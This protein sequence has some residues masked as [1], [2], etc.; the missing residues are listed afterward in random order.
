MDCYC[1]NLLSLHWPDDWIIIFK[2]TAVSEHR[3]VQ[4]MQMVSRGRNWT[5]RQINKSSDLSEHSRL[6]NEF[7][8]QGAH[9]FLFKK[10][11]A[12]ILKKLCFF[13]NKN[14]E[15]NTTKQKCSH[16]HNSTSALQVLVT[17]FCPCLLFQ[18][19]LMSLYIFFCFSSPHVL[20]LPPTPLWAVPGAMSSCWRSVLDLIISCLT[21]HLSSKRRSIRIKLLRPS[22]TCA[23]N[24]FASLA[25]MVTSAQQTISPFWV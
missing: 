18:T 7:P 22:A 19:F 8:H 10:R 2:Q 17:L 13:H 21:Q 6:L 25:N 3:A 16:A 12:F 23:K 15:V 14:S 24:A 1:L 4:I 5:S 11:M 9:Y 20:K